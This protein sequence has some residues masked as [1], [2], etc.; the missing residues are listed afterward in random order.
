[1]QMSDKKYAP[2]KYDKKAPD[3][4]EINLGDKDVLH[5][6]NDQR[7][8]AAF[9]GGKI[10]TNKDRLNALLYT[11]GIRTFEVKYPEVAKKILKNEDISKEIYQNAS[12]LPE[13]LILIQIKKDLHEKGED[14]VLDYIYSAGAAAL[15]PDVI[16]MNLPTG[17]PEFMNPEIEKE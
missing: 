6:Y 5:I 12:Q 9:M 15:C 8:M 1:M 10:D 4:I 2:Y 17:L 7:A 3:I 13:D 16:I 14:F 11:Y